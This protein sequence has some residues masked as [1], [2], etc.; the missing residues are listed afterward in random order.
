MKERM[1]RG[2]D[3]TTHT[4]GPWRLDDSGEWLIDSDGNYIEW[5]PNARRIVECVNE[6]VGV[7]NP[8]GY[9]HRLEKDRDELA[10]LLVRGRDL[11]IEAIAI[12]NKTAEQRAKLLDIAKLQLAEAERVEEIMLREAGIGV[13]DR[14]KI[15]KARALIAEI[16]VAQ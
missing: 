10:E 5:K 9:V 11:M 16:E 1:G 4:Q 12:Q 14:I 7:H 8:T 13:T 2:L 15:E 3:N 6:L